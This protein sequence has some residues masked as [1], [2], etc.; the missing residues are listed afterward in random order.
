MGKEGSPDIQEGHVMV[1]IDHPAPDVC[2]STG[3]GGGGGK[4][5]QIVRY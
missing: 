5:T 3:L 2:M 4:G 1:Q